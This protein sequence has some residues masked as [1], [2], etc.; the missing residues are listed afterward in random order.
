MMRQPTECGESLPANLPDKR[1][2]SRIHKELK[3]IGI[4]RTKNPINK[5]ANELHR[6]LSKEVQKANKYIKNCYTSLAITEM[7]AMYQ[8]LVPVILAA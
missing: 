6:Q 1:L 4:K 3:K 5:R 2:I 7:K 8:W